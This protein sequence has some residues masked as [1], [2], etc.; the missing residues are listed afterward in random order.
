[1]TTPAPLNQYLFVIGYIFLVPAL[2]VFWYCGG[3]R[4]EALQRNSLL[5]M[6]LGMAMVLYAAWPYR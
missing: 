1:M 2:A 5:V 4:L 3:R 6:G